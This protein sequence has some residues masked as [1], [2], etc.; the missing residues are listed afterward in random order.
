MLT[1][2]VVVGVAA[3]GRVAIAAMMGGGRCMR[4]GA[5]SYWT[6]VAMGELD[7]ERMMVIEVPICGRI[8]AS[9]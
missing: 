8:W 2:G 4:D 1:R 5:R 7:I 9:S 6:F 3:G